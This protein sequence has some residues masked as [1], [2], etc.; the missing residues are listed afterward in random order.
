MSIR[1]RP[2][3]W[4]RGSSDPLPPQAAGDARRPSGRHLSPL[5]LAALTAALTGGPPAAAQPPASAAD[6]GAPPPCLAS[7]QVTGAGDLTPAFAADIFHYAVRCEEPQTL[8]VSAAAEGDAR[9]ALRRETAAGAP[10]STLEETRVELPADGD[11]VV[12]AIAP[13]AGAGAA[14]GARTAYTVHCVPPDFPEVEVVGKA[15]GR[16]PGLLLI[17]PW[18]SSPDGGHPVSHIA[19]LDDNGVPRFQRRI[20]PGGNNF[21]WHER[22]RRYSYAETRPNG[23]GDVVLL[24]ERLEEVGRVNTVGGLAPAMMHEFLITEEGNYLFVVNE[25]AVRDL[26]R[27]PAPADDLPAPTAVQETRDAVIQEVAPDGREVFR[28]NSWEHLKLSDCLWRAFPGEYAKLN[29]LDVVEGG[30][31]ASFRAC[32]VVLRIERP[33]GRVA[34]QLGG[35]DPAEPDPYDSRR[36]T[37]DRPWYRPAG[38]PRGGFCAQHTALQPAPGRVLLFD[39]GQCLDGYRPSSRAVEY[40]LRPGGEAEFV[41]HHE[42]GRLA[43]YAGAVTVLPNGNWLISWGGGPGDLTLS[44]VDASGRELLALRLFKGLNQASTYRTWRHVGP[45]PPL[46][47]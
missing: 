16:A 11:L 44:E 13:G 5:L 43:A 25:P 4:V 12:E 47:P 39:N 46:R 15:P 8:K 40:R 32:S 27:Y 36:P 24:D 41:R 20:E 45:E 19:M 9:V 26:S 14:T 38:D 21:R 7:L 35:S 3:R 31:L 37:F 10:S 6:P 18:Y 30:L 2:V 23:A 22:A 34:W 29:S 17:S 1:R 33:S 28:W 42:P